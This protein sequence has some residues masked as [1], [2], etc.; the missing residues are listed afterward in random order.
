MAIRRFL[1]KQVIKLWH[2]SA[3]EIQ[4]FY[5]GHLGREYFHECQRKQNYELR[6]A[7]FNYHATYIERCF[8]GYWSRKYICDYYARKAFITASILAGKR[9]RVLCTMNYKLEICGEQEQAKRKVEVEINK[10]YAKNHH[11]VI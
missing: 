9:M 10:F 11:R 2:Q 4:R 1:V 7:Y 3:K 8:R 6:M 5:R